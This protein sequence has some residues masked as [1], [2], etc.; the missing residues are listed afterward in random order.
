[1]RSP[2]KFAVDKPLPEKTVEKL[3][4]ARKAELQDHGPK[5]GMLAWWCQ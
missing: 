4:A 2:L 1:V 3:I 5:A